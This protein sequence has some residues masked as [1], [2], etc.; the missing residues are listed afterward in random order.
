MKLVLPVRLFWPELAKQLQ[1]LPIDKLF[2]LTRIIDF[3]WESN[4]YG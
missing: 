3:Y 4:I 2:G 1:T